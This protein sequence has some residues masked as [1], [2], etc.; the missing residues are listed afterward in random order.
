MTGPIFW[1]RAAS[2]MMFLAVAIGAFAAHGL[3]DVLSAEMKAVFETGVRY[4]MAH[5]LA[6][7]AVAWLSDR[8]PSKGVSIAGWCFLLGIILFSG[9]LYALSLTGI[10][11]LGAITPLGGL[12]FLAGWSC[13]LFAAY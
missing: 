3:K 10:R 8:F 5:A 4:H 1:I 6:L 12:L 13:L 2:V 11:Q 7:F 9:S